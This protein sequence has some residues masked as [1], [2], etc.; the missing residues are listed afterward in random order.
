M[1][2]SIQ[3]K[4]D[5]T[6]CPLFNQEYFTQPKDPNALSIYN[7]LKSL[8][9]NLVSKYNNCIEHLNRLIE[10]Y[11]NH[12]SSTEKVK[13]MLV[14]PIELATRLRNTIAKQSLRIGWFAA[15][16]SGKSTILNRLYN[17]D[18]Q[19][20]EDYR[21]PEKCFLPITDN[22]MATSSCAFVLSRKSSKK[23]IQISF[24]KKQNIVRKLKAALKT[25]ASSN[26]VSFKENIN[27]LDDCKKIY[28]EWRNS[29]IINTMKSNHNILNYIFD[30]IEDVCAHGP[31]EK[32]VEN[33]SEIHDV[34]KYAKHGDPICAYVYQI[35]A[36]IVERSDCPKIIEMIDIPGSNAQELDK[37]YFEFIKDSLD[38]MIFMFKCGGQN[39][40]DT[41]QI[42]ARDYFVQ[43]MNDLKEADNNTKRF[44]YIYNAARS[45][46]AGNVQIATER[47]AFAW[48]NKF[49]FNDLS[50]LFF[51]DGHDFSDKQDRSVF[52]NINNYLEL[53]GISKY[54][55][56]L[57][58]LNTFGGLE[59]LRTYLFEK[60][61]LIIAQ[62]ISV[63][64]AALLDDLKLLIDDSDIKLRQLSSLRRP[65]LLQE[66]SQARYDIQNLK[67]VIAS[68]F[69]SL[70]NS[71]KELKSKADELFNPAARE[72]HTDPF[73]TRDTQFIKVMSSFC[74]DF[75]F[76]HVYPFIIEGLINKP[77]NDLCRDIRTQCRWSLD[78]ETSKPLV[79]L[80]QSKSPLNKIGMQ[81]LR[82]ELLRVNNNLKSVNVD[83][84]RNAIDPQ[85][86]AKLESKTAI[87]ELRD[88]S[89]QLLKPMLNNIDLNNQRRREELFDLAKSACI[90]LTT[91]LGSSFQVFWFEQIESILNHIVGLSTSVDMTN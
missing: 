68:D 55:E 14:E 4:I 15:S 79:E 56:L 13:G 90:K 77:M 84:F 40:N 75:V 11:P 65:D 22:E 72:K 85:F 35:V 58:H 24:L 48:I 44:I 43:K 71:V 91:D 88:Q 19:A 53:S 16:G 32:K 20:K 60:W 80:I 37:V 6:N 8:G 26:G 18:I 59:Y 74:S 10:K 1:S 9:E 30:F 54:V 67:L 78:S 25:M 2:S 17:D 62:E 47:G 7:D 34:I 5:L 31:H 86:F 49:L 57:K 83:L 27:S 81:Q 50:R 42:D 66:L 23:Q 29:S 87:N 38:A 28:E 61:P 63:F 41:D 51:F 3:P 70:K 82:D 33:F 46:D 89:E 39:I 21:N 76:I 12:C 45:V 64:T 52:N 36:E 73:Q 69:P